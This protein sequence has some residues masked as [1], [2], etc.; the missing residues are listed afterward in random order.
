MAGRAVVPVVRVEMEDAAMLNRRTLL[1][2]LSLG[3]LISFFPKKSKADVIPYRS[4]EAEAVVVPTYNINGP[5]LRKTSFGWLVDFELYADQEYHEM[6]KDERR[7][8]GIRYIQ[9]PQEYVL[10][11]TF[12]DSHNQNT[13]LEFRTF[14]LTLEECNSIKRWKA[15]AALIDFAD[16][17]DDKVLN[18]SGSQA[19][20]MDAT[21]VRIPG[22]PE[23]KTFR[24]ASI[25]Y[26]EQLG[27]PPVEKD[28]EV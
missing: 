13:I 24:L 7:R 26:S 18:E 28:D 27:T 2:V 11:A 23:E 19:D 6:F 3:G 21:R 1:G 14:N 10:K 8:D 20:W 22:I 15:K 5:L 12:Q 16:A 4:I 17:F 25:T 9:F